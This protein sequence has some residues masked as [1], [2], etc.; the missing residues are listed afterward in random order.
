MSKQIK[1]PCGINKN[2][3]IVYIE[4]AKNGLACECI[5]P[6]CKQP[7]VAK[8]EGKKNQAHYAHHNAVE[9][10]HGYQTALHYM[11]KDLF[12]EI[13]YL[14]FIKDGKPVQCK[15][16][17]VELEHRIDNIIPDI[18][19]ICDGKPFIVEIFVSHAVDDTKKAKI[20]DLS[21][22]A[23]EIDLSRFH[24]E[25]IDKETLKK[26]LC[27][28]VNF[29]WVYDA[30]ADLIA[31]KR[32]I[33]QQY[34]IKRRIDFSSF[35]ECPYVINKMRVKGITGIK[36]KIPL[37]VC[38]KCI[39]HYKS[40]VSGFISCGYTLPFPLNPTTVRKNM[41]NILCLKEKVMFKTEAEN[42]ISDF[43]KLLSKSIRIPVQL[44]IR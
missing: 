20:K 7:L 35:V 44:T 13:K 5:C 10:E 19:V 27:N 21:I 11:A 8:N 32:E 23:I 37:C 31:Q 28:P 34:G 4:D 9:C 41:P 12:L 14:T 24:N 38:E 16:D 40:K 18:L 36:F 1:L 22:S 43:E 29:S 39:N 2:G 25:I 30:D 3:E 26:E 15:I 42:Y 33:I 6:S 17:S